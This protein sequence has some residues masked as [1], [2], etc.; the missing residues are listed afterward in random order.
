MVSGYWGMPD[1]IFDAMGYGDIVQALD[2]MYAAKS[3]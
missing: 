2:A 3:K 1:I